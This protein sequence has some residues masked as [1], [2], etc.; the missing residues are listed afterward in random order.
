[1][2]YRVGSVG[3]LNA[4]P[5]VSCLDPAQVQVVT[6]HPAGVAQR[7]AAGEVDVALVPVA[8]VLREGWAL[9][10]GWCIGSFGP[11]ESVLLAAELPIEQWTDVVLDGES[12]TSVVLARLLLSDSPLAKRLSSPVRFHEAAPGTSIAQTLGTTAAVI[13]G[14]AALKLPDR[15]KHRIDLA[16]EWTAWTGLP[17]V[18]AAW[19]TRGPVDPALVAHLREA[20]RLG[21]SQ[22][23]DRWTGPQRAYLTK[24]IR[25]LLDDDALCGL[26]RFAALAARAGLLPRCD[27]RLV[28]PTRQVRP[29]PV[30]DLLERAARRDPLTG[31]EILRLAQQARTSD[32]VLAANRCRRKDPTEA[33]GPLRIAVALSMHLPDANSRIQRAA[34]LG[35][36]DV[37]VLGAVDVHTLEKHTRQYADLRFWA[38]GCNPAALA[39]AGAYG[40][41]PDGVGTLD[42]TT[43]TLLG[44]DNAAKALHD[45]AAVGRAGLR[46]IG[47]LIV[48]QGETD[49]DRLATLASYDALE[50]DHPVF[51]AVIVRTALRSG[52]YGS[53]ATTAMDQ[54][55][56]LSVAALVLRHVQSVAGAPDTEGAGLAQ[57]ALWAGA[58]DFGTVVLDGDPEHWGREI[59]F[60]RHH[61]DS[62]GDGPHRRTA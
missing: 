27:V 1:M 16:A 8:S 5:L 50:A 26:R 23:A 51:D 15:L 12:R 34:T 52:P 31:E 62:L 17:F 47:E 36:T 44:A 3:Y 20:G 7:L 25:Y 55:R 19:A 30:V 4:Q 13:I 32:L 2:P 60:A 28:G 53:E 54:V 38:R 58:D 37:H 10:P 49:A 41:L 24:S 42:D 57:V 39:A 46:T 29:P 14:D 18:F 22:I 56:W 61:L 45:L 40:W 59:A 43:R 35:A 6:D 11:V 21:V 9:L 33:R 48:G